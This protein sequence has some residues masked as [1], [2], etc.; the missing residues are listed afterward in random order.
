MQTLSILTASTRNVNWNVV[1]KRRK[2]LGSLL[3]VALLPCTLLKNDLFQ[4]LPSLQ[5]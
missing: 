1:F 2:T 3:A 5:S 4:L